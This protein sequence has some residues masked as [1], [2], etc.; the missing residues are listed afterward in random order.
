MQVVHGRTD[1]Q[2]IVLNKLNHPIGPTK[3]VVTE[4]FSFLGTLARNE[5]FCPLNLTW[6]KLKTH[7]KMWSYIQEKY[8]ILNNGKDWAIRS[9]DAAFRG[10]KSRLKKDHFYAYPN[11]EIRREKR[12]TS[13][14]E[15]IFDDI[16]A[17]WNLEEAENTFK[18]NK[19][20]R[21]K[22]KY[23]HT[24]GK[25]S[26]ALIRKGKKTKNSGA[27]SNKKFFVATRTRKPNR[28]YKDLSEEITNKIVEMERVE[29]QEIED[30]TQ[31]TDA[32]TKVMG[33]DH[34]GRVR[35]LG[36][37]VIKTLIK[38]KASDSG[39]SSK[40]DELVEKRLDDLEERMQK[41]MNAQRDVIEREVTMNIF[42]QL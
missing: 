15:P 16:L 21:K 28:I 4:F 41:R 31:S 3:A 5:T 34:H 37:G 33:P 36:G 8:D 23:P 14:P 11:D 12:P 39:S 24:M 6:T 32:F 22:F 18:T 40:S 30:S 9:I 10:C 42:A 2:L 20:N 38:Q 13:V 29:T 26:F 1:R 27:L 17:Y 7:D 25:T 19:E 35:L